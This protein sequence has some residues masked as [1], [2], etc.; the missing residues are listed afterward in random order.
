[1]WMAPCFFCLAPVFFFFF[2]VPSAVVVA[3]FRRFFLKILLPLIEREE[4]GSVSEKATWLLVGGTMMA[5]S[6]PNRI[7][8]QMGSAHRTCTIK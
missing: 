1:M 3:S 7:Y 2:T 8:M 4:R 6:S 5:G